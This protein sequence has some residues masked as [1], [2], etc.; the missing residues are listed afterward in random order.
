M[1][2]GDGSAANEREAVRRNQQRRGLRAAT[3]AAVA[4][5]VVL[6]ALPN[7]RRPGAPM[8][9]GILLV[10]PDRILAGD[11]PLRDFE[12]FYGPAGFYL[13]AG[14]FTAFGTGLDTERGVAV[15]YDVVIVLALFALVLPWGLIP[16]AASALVAGAVCLADGIAAYPWFGGL[17]FALVGLACLARAARAPTTKGARSRVLIAA[18]LASGVA[19]L[20]RPDIAPPVILGCLPLLTL[21]AWPDAA[22]YVLGLLVGVSPALPFGLTVGADRL[23]QVIRD[24]QASQAGRGLPL[25]PPISAEVAL[26]LVTT[27][28]LTLMLLVVAVLSVRR[29]P[30]DPDGRVLL[31]LGLFA[32]GIYPYVLRRADIFH[33]VDVAVVAL[34]TAPLLAAVALRASRRGEDG[35][36]RQT[37]VVSALSLAVLAVSPPIARTLGQDFAT[38]VGLREEV[39]YEVARGGRSFPLAD[40]ERAESIEHIISDLQ[41]ASSAG[42]VVFVGPRDLRRT[43]YLETFIYFLVPELRPGSFFLEMNPGTANRSGSSLA[44]E[45]AH[46]D[47]LV[48]SSRYDKWNE[49]NASS[50]YGSAEPNRVV[51]RDF[52]LRTEHGQYQLYGRC[53]GKE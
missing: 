3:V 10:Y 31:A 32:A 1:T 28:A 14:A 29:H 16:A 51:A 26:L 36:R 47:F 49:P 15:A 30:R 8:D 35:Y 5:L 6:L 41:R 11:V 38:L 48:L 42:E 43:N 2:T 40:R 39:S 33:V 12:T 44:S 25:F 23:S 46:A 19:I 34:A 17:A 13:I 20:F 9:E 27:T 21:M 7:F 37:I 24:L 45:V 18:G 50:D 22:R 4:L 53:E 52:C